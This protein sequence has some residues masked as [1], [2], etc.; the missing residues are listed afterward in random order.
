MKSGGPGVLYEV[1]QAWLSPDGRIY[2]VSGIRRRPARPDLPARAVLRRGLAGRGAY[3]ERNLGSTAGW[4]LLEDVD[5][6]R[7]TESREP[8]AGADLLPGANTRPPT[9]PPA[10]DPAADGVPVGWCI[11]RPPSPGRYLI[12][13]KGLPFAS[14]P[15]EVTI[16]RSRSRRVILFPERPVFLSSLHPKHVYWQRIDRDGDDS[17]DGAAGPGDLVHGGESL[18]Q[19]SAP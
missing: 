18:Q 5:L 7:I 9:T 10:M 13:V 16:I 15:R 4:Q 1:G 14:K 6:Q 12:V 3:R 2:V 8:D 11:G 17:R 19:R